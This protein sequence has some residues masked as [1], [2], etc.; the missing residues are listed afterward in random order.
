MS[1]GKSLGIGRH[2]GIR[3]TWEDQAP[4]LRFGSAG[5]SWKGWGAA[6]D[7]LYRQVLE[8]VAPEVQ[9][10][11][12]TCKLLRRLES[13]CLSSLVRVD[14]QVQDLTGLFDWLLISSLNAEFR[15]LVAI[16][17]RCLE[18]IVVRQFH[19]DER[20]QLERSLTSLIVLRLLG[21]PYRSGCPVSAGE[22]ENLLS[23]LHVLCG[24]T[25]LMTWKEDS[26][27]VYV[28]EADHQ[29]FVEWV[30][31]RVTSFL[32]RNDWDKV[33]SDALWSAMFPV[34]ECGTRHE[35]E[36]RPTWSQSH[37]ILLSG[38]AFLEQ[39]AVLVR[40]SDL[41]EWVL[42]FESPREMDRGRRVHRVMTALP[43]GISPGQVWIWVPT[44][45]LRDEQGQITCH[46]ATA[47]ALRQALCASAGEMDERLIRKLRR[48][49]VRTSTPALTGIVDC[50]RQG[51]VVADKGIWEPSNHT[52][53]LVDLIGELVAWAG[54]EENGSE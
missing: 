8:S 38:T 3:L 46:M 16:Y 26:K 2:T 15:R 5:P 48:E 11:H 20:R 17:E 32:G 37:P 28:V 47:R 53:S 24:G 34:P 31:E 39:G 40:R 14:G 36:L 9:E 30:V 50:Y 7:R 23:S 29:R 10:A 43:R 44:Q 19:G 1:L 51:M 21:V 6:L 41:G 49:Y 45:P 33:V 52:G 42:V 13:L 54:P 35:R 4:P 18:P 22:G 27:P 25:G 12:Y